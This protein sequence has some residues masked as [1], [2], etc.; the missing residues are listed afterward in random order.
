[1]GECPSPLGPSQ[2]P[3]VSARWIWTTPVGVCRGSSWGFRLHS[4]DDTIS[5]A[6]SLCFLIFAYLLCELTIQVFV[7]LSSSSGIL[8]H[9]QQNLSLYRWC[10]SCAVTHVVLAGLGLDSAPDSRHL[11]M[12]SKYRISWVAGERPLG[13]RRQRQTTTCLSSSSYLGSWYYL[14]S[15]SCLGCSLW[16]TLPGNGAVK[17]FHKTCITFTSPCWQ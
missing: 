9:H 3:G 14:S 8:H 6:P 13:S 11:C 17:W 1:M 5:W 2:S 4:S 10:I 12:T 7:F 16:S 15:G